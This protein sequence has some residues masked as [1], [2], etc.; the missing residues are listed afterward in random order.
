[1]NTYPAQTCQTCGLMLFKKRGIWKH[2]KGVMCSAPR[3]RNEGDNFLDSHFVRDQRLGDAQID[4]SVSVK[5]RA[6][7]KSNTLNVQEIRER[8]EI[9]QSLNQIEQTYKKQIMCLLLDAYINKSKENLN[10]AN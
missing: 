10:V 4:L 7:F 8:E 5:I 2:K 3:P 6:D 1:M 9:R